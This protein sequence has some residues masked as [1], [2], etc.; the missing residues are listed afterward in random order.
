MEKR[1]YK[2]LHY[3]DRQTIE[4]M[5]KQGSSVK[6]IAEALGTHRD[7]IYRVFARQ[8]NKTLILQPDYKGLKV[9]ADLGKT[10]LARGLYQDIEAGMINKMSWA[11]SVAE[12]SY[13]RETHTRTILKI[14]KVYDV[15]A[16]SIP[17]NGDTEISARAFASRSYEQE[18][19]EL[20]KRR[21]AILKIRASL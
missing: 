16:V 18:R 6:D 20:L 15:S 10:D 17:A 14:K 2:R 7:T 19:Q 3:E 12:E 13:D 9:A 11:F 8:S 21:A 5:S 4:A 1:K